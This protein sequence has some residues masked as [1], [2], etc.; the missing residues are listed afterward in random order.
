MKLDIMC[1]LPLKTYT[2]P[3]VSKQHHFT[4][5]FNWLESDLA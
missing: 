2:Y 3:I 4:D 1:K 5:L